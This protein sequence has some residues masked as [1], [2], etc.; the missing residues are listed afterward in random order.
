[1][2]QEAVSKQLAIHIDAAEKNPKLPDLGK[3]GRCDRADC[4]EEFETGFGLACGGFGVYEYCT[5]CSK[6]VSKTCE[7]YNEP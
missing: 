2:E 4:P 1:M 5:V 7:A 6:V 3:A